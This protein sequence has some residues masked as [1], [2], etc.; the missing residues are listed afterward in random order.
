MNIKANI[1]I[2]CA[3]FIFSVSLVHADSSK[4][5]RRLK[6]SVDVINEIMKIPEKGIPRD[7]LQK[8]RAVAVFP[9]LI[10]GGFIVGVRSGRGV[11][12]ARH[13]KSGRWSS[14][15]FFSLHGGSAGFQAGVQSVDLILLIMNNRGLNALLESKVTLGADLGVAAGPVGR[16]TET[17]TDA[18]LDAEIQSYSRSRGIFAGVSIEGATINQDSSANATYYGQVLSARD[19]L[20]NFDIKPPASA[21]ELIK[22]LSSYTSR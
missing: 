15:A 5:D 17:G 1:F 10:K 12:L 2:L 3:V 7:L 18:R 20:T 19:I 6:N 13:E 22:T 8:C 14:P 21:K 11:L 4:F 16:R 9:G